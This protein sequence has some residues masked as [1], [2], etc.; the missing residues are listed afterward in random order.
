MS[1]VTRPR[2][3]LPARVYWTRR[4]LVLAV[5]TV[6]VVGL[7]RVLGGASDGADKP[8][9]TAQLSGS[10][11]SASGGGTGRADAGEAGEQ[12]ASADGKATK[13]KKKNKKKRKQLKEAEPT[14]EPLPEP[15]GTCADDDIVIEPVVTDAAAGS[16]VA[17]TLE[18]STRESPA[19]T[20]TVSR[21]SLVVNVTS[22]KD[23]IWTTRHCPGGLGSVEVVARKDTPAEVPMRWSGRRSDRE[24]SNQTKWALPGW[25]HVEA[26]AYAGEPVST[27]FELGRPQP[28]V[29]TKTVAPE[30]KK[31]KK[32]KRN[33]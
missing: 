12:E 15:T 22:G 5:A 29:V 32:K 31:N 7:A 26:A 4:L 28:A 1:S 6:L 19:C 23:D 33:R 13:N 17:I 10:Q 21:E 25:Y 14:E 18:V 16:N 30:P 3:P 20:W 11:S 9:Q 24:C 2:G 8:G 27:Q